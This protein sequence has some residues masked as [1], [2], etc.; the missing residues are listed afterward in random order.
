LFDEK[1]VVNHPFTS[2]DIIGRHVDNT[3]GTIA[4]EIC[5][6]AGVEANGGIVICHHQPFSGDQAQGKYTSSLPLLIPRPF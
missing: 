4:A 1:A 3:W 5:S 2:G 6:E